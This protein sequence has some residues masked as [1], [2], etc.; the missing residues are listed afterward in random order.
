MSLPNIAH[1]IWRDLITGKKDIAF[2][3]LAVKV[4][5]GTARIK[6][7]TDP[8]ELPNLAKEIMIFFEKNQHLPTAKKDIAKLA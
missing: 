4:A 5:L 6:Y 3:F 7:K 1:P 8:S 2:E